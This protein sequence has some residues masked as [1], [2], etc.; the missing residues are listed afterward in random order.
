MNSTIKGN[1]FEAAY[2][3][4]IARL[5]K[6]TSTDDN[7]EVILTKPVEFIDGKEINHLPNDIYPLQLYHRVNS[8]NYFTDDRYDSGDG[9][10]YIGERAGMIMIIFAD[11]QRTS[12]TMEDLAHRIIVGM[13]N[14]IDPSRVCKEDIKKVSISINSVD[15]DSEKVFKGETALGEYRLKPQSIYM[16]LTYTIESVSLKNCYSCN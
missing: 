5:V 9:D 8:I 3:G 6:F 12:L 1:T 14:Y 10:K 2:F 4:G 16:S 11:E 7:S 13:G 15:T